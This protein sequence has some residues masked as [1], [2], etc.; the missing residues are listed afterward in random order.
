VPFIA[1]NYD[2]MSRAVTRKNQKS[3]HF[4]IRF[5]GFPI[6]IPCGAT[7]DNKKNPASIN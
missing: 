6:V 2:Q 1:V 7:A 5:F 3:F 4:I